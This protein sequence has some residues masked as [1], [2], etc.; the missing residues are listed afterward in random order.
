[1]SI[2]IAFSPGDRAQLEARGISIDEACRQFE[3]LRRQP[4]PI[5][6]ERPCTIGDG[7]TRL[8]ESE[9]AALAAT[10]DAAALDGRVMKFVPASGAAT[11]MF[12]DLIAALGDDTAPSRTPA[13]GAFFERLDEFPFSADLRQRAGLS[14]P[15]VGEE[16]ERR[17]LRTLL[18]EMRYAELPK[19]LIPFHRGSEVRTPFEEHLLEAAAYSRARSGGARTHLTVAP[20]F[21]RDFE[22]ALHRV[23][24][25][26]T[27]ATGGTD[28]SVSF[29]E[30]HPSTDTVCITTEGQPFRLAD[31]TLLLRP[32]G[33]GALLPNLAGLRADLVVI[34]NIDN[35]VPFERA[36]E[37][38]DWKRQL[39]GL[40]ASLHDRVCRWLRELDAPAATETAVDEARAFAAHTFG[41]RPAAALHDVAAKRAFTVDALNRPLRVC[42]VV[43]NEGEPGGAPFWVRD[44]EGRVTP[45]IVEA[46]Q[47]D[48]ADPGQK[49]IF[50]SSTHFNPVD[51]VCVLGAC[52]GQA[53][54]LQRFVDHSAVFL[55][56]KSHDGRELIALERP[57]L[58]NGA[59]AHWNTV[60]VEVPASTFAPVKTVFD[61][62]RPQH[63]SL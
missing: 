4:Q 46:S 33:H 9:R 54:D 55:S 31:G 25:R 13:G 20:E 59:M 23:A 48:M 17:V 18:D 43:K 16:Q 36:E 42:G 8:R 11:R 44:D 15:V 45:Q 34:K 26:V 60:F 28:V 29:S 51:I 49:A 35:V 62:L 22:E 63:Q 5:R 39:I 61:L 24:P 53:H 27:G 10:A 1:M 52:D 56:R 50:D 12:K 37:V 3:L 30:Q 38:I 19:A 2:R 40:A 32:A 41:R 6:L 21:R 57:G 47:V 14:G 7:I 58:W